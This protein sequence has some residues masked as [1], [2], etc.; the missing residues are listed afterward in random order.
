VIPIWQHLWLMTA[1]TH[2]QGHPRTENHLPST[3][4][5]NRYIS[6]VV[7]SSCFFPSSS[8]CALVD[9]SSLLF[10]YSPESLPFFPL[11]TPCALFACVGVCGCWYLSVVTSLGCTR[12][13]QVYGLSSQ[14]SERQKAAFEQ[15]V[16]APARSSNSL[17]L[18]RTL[19]NNVHVHTHS[20][21]HPHVHTITPPSQPQ[22]HARTCSPLLCPPLG[23]RPGSH[24]VSS[25]RHSRCVR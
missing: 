6:R 8:L 21:T 5:P 15:Q 18:S 20:S 1:R 22:Q 16:S 14:A 2:P 11:L 25:G 9:R 7:Q 19:S 3:V 4:P 23:R 17:S 10:F 13:S 12:S 24:C